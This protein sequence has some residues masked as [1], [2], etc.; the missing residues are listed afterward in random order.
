MISRFFIH[1]PI[2]AAVIS[3]LIVLIGLVALSDLPIEQYP[4][5]TPPQI[6]VS[7]TY[8][9]ASAQIVSDSV[10]AALE[11]QINGVEDMIY[12]Y[13]Q[14]SASGDLALSVYFNIGADVDKALNNV[15]DRVDLALSQLPEEPQK[16]GVIVKKETP[17]IL[18]MIAVESPNGRYDEIFTSNYATIY[19]AD[20]ILRLQGVSDAKLINARDYSMRIWLRPDRMAQLG[21]SAS[22]VVNSIREQN[23]D[24][25][26]GELGQAPT[27]TPVP[28]TLTVSGLGR[29]S[30]PEQFENIILRATPDG[31]TVLIKD[32]GS[33]E[34]GASDYSVNGE[35]RGKSTALIAVY[36]EYG[37]N[38]LDVAGAVKKTMQRLYE[39][40]PPGMEYSIPYDTTIFIKNSIEEVEVTLYEAAGLVALV[41]L[42]FL[43]SVRATVI[44]I[45]AMIVSIVGTFAGMHLL[46]FSLNTLTL[47][48]LVLSI[49]IVVDDAIVVVENVDRNIREKGLSPKDAALKAM[50]EVSSPIIAIVFVLCAVFIPVAFLG[51]IAG[52][53]YKQFAI[54][55]AIS[56]VLSGIVALTLSPVLASLLLKKNPKK[57]KYA[58]AFNRF[59]EKC[60]HGYSTGAAW[61]IDRPILGIGG[62]VAI[63][64]AIFMFFRII[65]T[66]LVPQEDQGYLFAFANLPE[67]SSLDRADAVTRQAEPIA[68][69][70]P[71][72]D[73]FISLTGFSLLENLNRT[74]VGT[75][76][77]ILKDWKERKSSALKSDG[78]LK[79][80]S[81]Q[82]YGITEAQVMPFVP[83][84]IQGLGTVG[85]FEFWILN[86]GEGGPQD[87]QDTTN[88]FIEAA[89]KRPELSS[90]STAMQADC[91][92]VFADLDRV[93]AR[94]LNVS[95]G[96]VYTTLQS[97]LGSIYVNNFNKYG[98]I[99][100]V[101]V[102]SEPEFR[103]SLEDIG[104]IYVRSE[105][106]DMVPL[107]AL[108]TFN[109]SSGP[110]LISR[111]NTF[112]AAKIIGM[113]A[114]GFSSGQAMSA[115]EE[116]A[117][118]ILPLE[119][120]YS[121]SG[122]AYQEKATGGTSLS[123]LIGAL[124][125]VFLIL[126]ALYERWSLP[127]AVL[128]AVPFGIL[129]ALAA[130]WVRGLEN[131][132]YF[133][134]GL[135]TLIAL[136]AKNAILI[137]EFAILRRKEG[138]GVREAVLEAAK[139]R[140]RAI[141]M[142]SL[143][144]IFGVLPL[145]ISSGAG[146]ASR[147]SVGTGVM[148]GMILATTL[149]IF[150]I[151]LFY[152]MLD[153]RKN[154]SA[155]SPV[156]EDKKNEK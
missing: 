74:T 24:Y 62:F 109:Y 125:L 58:D 40:F 118:E 120:A 111:F 112:P 10:A 4:N 98:H 132:V 96:D 114:P 134:I 104:N 18:L 81:K 31:S 117:K 91:I 128:L 48:G 38:A 60:T 20:E 147:H 146:A 68:M 89:K 77:I 6:Q 148:G 142:T 90:I 61:L 45:V 122:E 113:A 66:S 93:K 78:V 19:V 108:V 71:A 136:A 73:N 55:I 107:K 130:I 29:L 154:S 95:I 3:I 110:D 39:R 115:M 92:Q 51:G 35:M 84:A 13:S 69:H 41:I 56:V 123:A 22:D 151:P 129:G 79:E 44:P 76:F 149:G 7:T 138:V 37:A 27:H 47:F 30:T 86:Q 42:L 12:M 57:N 64:L 9:G 133:Q 139:Q 16:E 2:F 49:G 23:A 101:M 135:V 100:Q 150:F 87:L 97:F 11:N 50:E 102:Q 5:I 119:M 70:N 124:V 8:P 94:A 65:P 28:L 143:T 131:D 126:S 32:V 83:P 52:G 36:Q 155:Q 75:Y 88:K 34:L 140:F 46:G 106:G 17:T 144:F 26:I 153:R 14:N 15:Q 121:W 145:V 156:S 116:V 103:S 21:I 43:H 85:G 152:S 80:L 1:R 127:I 82:F 59:L 72:V 63:L 33:V 54:T 105:A 25:P 141:I 137:V 99:F 67:G 53:L